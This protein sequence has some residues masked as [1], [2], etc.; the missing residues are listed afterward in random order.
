VKLVITRQNY[1]TLNKTIEFLADQGAKKIQLFYPESLP[2]EYS[3]LEEYVPSI[4]EALPFVNAALIKINELGLEFLPRFT[5]FSKRFYN[6][7]WVKKGRK[8]GAKVGHELLYDNRLN[9]DKKPL[10]TVVIPTYNRSK[11]LKNTLTS[12]FNQTFP[13][14]R[15]EVIVVDDG[16]TDD[17]F[18]MIKKLNPPYRLRYFLQDDLG[19]GPGRARNIG[20]LYANGDI[21]LFIDSD[22][23]SDPKNIEEH[24]KSHAYYK[25]KFDHEV[26]VIG[27]R[28]D[29]HTN[30]D[31][32]ALLN[33]EIILNDFDRIR[34]IPARPDLREDFFKWCDDEPSNFHAPW[35][36]I[37][38]NNLS[39]P[40]KHMLEVGLIDE[41]F[42]FWGVEDQEL[43]Y[44]LQWL[45]FVLNSRAIGYHQHHPVVYH[46]KAGMDKAFK[47]NARIFYKK[48]LNPKIYEIYK[49][50]IHNRACVVQIN[51][52]TINDSI[53][54]RFMGRKPGK[55]KGL[56]EVKKELELYYGEG[57][58]EVTF[59]G[60]NPLLHPKIKQMLNFAK[61]R[62]E[63]ITIDTEAESLSKL[64]TCIDVI[65]NGAN[66]FII[67]IGGS[68]PEH[69]DVLM[70][71]K[72]S[73]DATIRAIKNLSMLNQEFRVR[74]LIS[75]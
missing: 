62:F 23:I 28:L 6:S 52:A 19:Y 50:W 14:D 29:L 43:G 55:V 68:N 21:M 41:S 58:T 7:K 65:Q 51:D 10:V 45:R 33:P 35:H 11:I 75:K 49:P 60:G 12:L 8:T 24:V 54:F 31:I 73:F 44:R 36:M 47:Y 38:T 17:T 25:K 3:K 59:I 27:K 5:P 56:D 42:V 70:N 37:F 4:P 69:H 9:F 57:D 63:R 64:K 72:G 71:R 1:K 20:T 34:K 15:F 32:Q 61:E 40:R 53:F 18:E 26:V 16:S 22:V 39:I 74:L 46:S 13:A 66:E 48:Y 30:S 2:E 67:N